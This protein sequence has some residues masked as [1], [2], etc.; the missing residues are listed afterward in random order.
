MREFKTTLMVPL[1]LDHA[2]EL[3]FNNEQVADMMKQKNPHDC[4]PWNKNKRKIHFEMPNE[5]I[6]PPLL[7]IIGG[8]KLRITMT[9]IKKEEK[10]KVLIIN[11][12][13]P[14]I[15][16][17]EL[18]KIRPTFT[19]SE[20]NGGTAF[21]IRCEMHAVFPPPLDSIIEEFMLAAIKANYEWFILSIS[22]ISAPR[23]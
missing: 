10:G 19:L 17:A 2:F 8:G 22:Q 16:G 6:P 21:D 1:P 23:S 13:R 3:I 9:Q 20:S 7:Q 4:G 12:V 5:N 18:L 11:K 15:L 14:H